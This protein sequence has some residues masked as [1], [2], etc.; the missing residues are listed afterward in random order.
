MM[1][2]ES[3]QEESERFNE[4][5]RELLSANRFDEWFRERQYR[6]NIE[7]GTPFFNESGHVPDAERHSPSQL[8]QC[9]RKVFYRQHNAPEEHSDP[10]GIF[11]FGTRFEEDLLFPFLQSVTSGPGTYVRNSI[12]IDFVAEAADVELQIKGMTDPVIVDASATPILPTEIK[13]KSSIDSLTSPDPRHRAQLHAYFLGLSEKYDIELNG[14]FLIYGSRES[15]DGKFFYVEFDEDFWEDTVLQWA[16]THTEHRVNDEL[17]PAEP[18]QHWECGFCEYRE[19]CGKGESRHADTRVSGFLAGYDGYPR[20]KV[21]EY[22]EGDA[23]AK[24][25]PSLAEQYPTLADYHDVA[26]WQCKECSS[27]VELDVLEDSKDPLCPACADK[28]K[29]SQVT[30]VSTSEQS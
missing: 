20:E 5:L 12:W 10:D 15:L 8:L 1:S 30:L 13:T 18:E 3:K 16:R 14:G 2:T 7:N 27:A 23:D 21:V 29:I 11:W 25:T 9:H 22:L 26:V 17:P 24:L 6:R 28:G 19:R 4:D